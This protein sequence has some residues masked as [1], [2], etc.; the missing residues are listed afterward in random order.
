MAWLLFKFHYGEAGA[1]LSPTPVMMM[2]HDITW[3][4]ARQCGHHPRA[5]LRSWIRSGRRISPANF[6]MRSR[7][8]NPISAISPANAPRDGHEVSHMNWGCEAAI[9]MILGAAEPDLSVCKS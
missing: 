3:A 9:D 6:A 1:R 7:K 8:N 4:D 2:P 5:P